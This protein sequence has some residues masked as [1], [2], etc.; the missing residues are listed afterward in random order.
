MEVLELIGGHS[1]RPNNK[2]YQ[3]IVRIFLQ[4]ESTANLFIPISCERT[5]VNTNTNRVG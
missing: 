2:K 5:C 3:L 1:I 4:F